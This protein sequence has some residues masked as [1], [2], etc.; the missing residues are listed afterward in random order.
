MEH[1]F[2]KSLTNNAL[3]NL[4]AIQKRKLPNEA[5]NCHYVSQLLTPTGYLRLYANETAV[6]EIKFNDEAITENPNAITSLAKEQM[7]EY[8][9]G[10]R[11]EFDLP[12]APKGTEFQMRVWQQL[13]HVAYGQTASYLDIAK[14][15]NKP[16]ACRAVG[17]ANGK[18]PI[19]IVIP[20]HRVIGASGK[21]TGYAGGL[22]R[23]SFLLSLESE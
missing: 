11:Q 16:T 14:A 22:S 23:K 13:L 4:S 18:N 19:A 20:C 5:D 3:A 6:T 15:L 17:A 2:L 21:L 8:L 10:T 12:L 1:I 7:Q 9:A